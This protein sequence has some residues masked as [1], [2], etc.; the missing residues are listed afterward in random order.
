M[1]KVQS[2][3]NFAKERHLGMIRKDSNVPHYEHLAAV[4]ARLK[5]LG[6]TD[7]DT[8]SAAWLHDIINYTDTSF[9]ELDQRFSSRVAVL[10][11][12]MSKDKNLPR[13]IQEEQYVKQLKESTLEAKLIKLCDISSSIKDLKNSSFSKTKKIKEMKKKLYYLNVIKTDLIK[14]KAQMPGIIG[15]VNGINDI[16]TSYGLRPVAFQ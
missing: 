9:D 8:L 2:A 14:N 4:V 15:F 16:V 3:E 7:E 5:N 10:V 12:S 6:V 11:L 13:S 1:S